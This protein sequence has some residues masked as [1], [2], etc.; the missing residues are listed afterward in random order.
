MG[1]GGSKE[2]NAENAEP[3]RIN[4]GDPGGQYEMTTGAGAGVQADGWKQDV[5]NPEN[6]VVYFDMAQAGNI[7]GLLA[8]KCALA[9]G[10]NFLLTTGS[11]LSQAN[12]SAV[13]SSSS[14]KTSRPPLLRTSAASAPASSRMV[15][16]SCRIRGARFIGLYVFVSFTPNSVYAL[17]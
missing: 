15:G 10:G 11:T 1:C 7:P 12:L 3:A 8:S 2:A 9:A 4:N 13:S 17:L 5:M 14:S 16:R 6:P